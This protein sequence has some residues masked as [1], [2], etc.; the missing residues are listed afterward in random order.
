MI[1]VLYDESCSVCTRL[2][3]WLARRDGVV[4]VGIGSPRG[5]RELRDLPAAERTAAFHAIDAQGRRRSG[6]AALPLVLGALPGGTVPAAL[7]ASFPRLAEL[8]YATIAR[9]RRLLSRLL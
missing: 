5:A 4:A 7:A 8:G 1:T 6:G 2:A 9:H 3:A